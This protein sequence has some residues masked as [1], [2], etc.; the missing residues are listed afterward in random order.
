ML[1]NEL[2]LPFS[3]SALFFLFSISPLWA[4]VVGNCCCP[5]TELSNAGELVVVVVFVQWFEC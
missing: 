3:S 5:T 2:L 1:S 4:V